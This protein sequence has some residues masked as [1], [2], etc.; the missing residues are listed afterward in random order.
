[1]QGLE[2]LALEQAVQQADRRSAHLGQRL[3]HGRQRGGHDRCVLDVVEADDGEIVGHAD[4]ALRE[5]PGST[6]IAMLS[7]KAKIAVGGSGRSSSCSAARGPG[8]DLG[9]RLHLEREVGQDPADAS[10]AW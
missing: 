7:L 1:V 8:R 4:A 2:A 3:P 9:D 6:P 10:A 5:P